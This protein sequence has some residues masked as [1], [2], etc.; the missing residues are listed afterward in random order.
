MDDNI[1][2]GRWVKNFRILTAALIF[3]GALNI[4]LLAAFAFFILEEKKIAFPLSLP[5]SAAAGVETTNEHLLKEMAKLSFRELVSFL[6]NKDFIEEGY[7]KRDLALSALVSV[8]HFNLERALFGKSIQKRNLEFAQVSFEVY[9]GLTDEQF[10]AIIRY[11]YE[12]KW[13]LTSKGIFIALQKLGIPHDPSLEEAFFI[14]PEF[15]ALE[16]LFQKT[17]VPQQRNALLKL[18]C[19]G[20]WDLL[21][22]FSREQDQMLDL[23]VEKRRRLLL[24]YLSLHSSAA[25]QLI[26]Q[27]DF[28]FALKRLEDRGILDLLGLLKDKTDDSI[29][30]CVEL[31]RSP[32]SDAIWQA[33]AAKLYAFTGEQPFIGPNTREVQPEVVSQEL[34]SFKEPSPTAKFH[35]VKEGESLWKIA[36]QYKVKLDDLVRLN[37]LEKDRLYPGMTLRIPNQGTGSEPPR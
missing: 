25:A 24:S 15:S 33:S 20:N 31:L 32:R 8:Y 5:I 1:F 30:F 18:A 34:P 37:D 11:A 14:T 7:T 22:R 6:T 9:P 10:E 2:V 35:V 13:P 26:L 29:R 4:G 19:E 36:R 17:E 12:E 16:V 27:T 28:A 3:S 21:E 23:S